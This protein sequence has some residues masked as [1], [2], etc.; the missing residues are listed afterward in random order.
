LLNHVPDEALRFCSTGIQR[1]WWD[2]GLCG[3]VPEESCT[4]LWSIPVRY[5]DLVT[6]LNEVS[7]FGHRASHVVTLFF[8]RPLLSALQKC[9]TA[10]CYN[11]QC[12]RQ[13]Y[14]L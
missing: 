14:H 5:D 4:N 1:E 11:D 9:V 2:D 8:N 13:R 7:D 6:F 3:L 10:K 12:I